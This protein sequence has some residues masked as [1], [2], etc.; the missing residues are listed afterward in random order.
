MKTMFLLT[1]LIS[2]FVFSPCLR[3]NP[4]NNI[5]VYKFDSEDDDTWD[6]KVKN[7]TK[8]VLKIQGNPT[9]GYSW[10]IK[11]KQMIDKHLLRVGNLG[12]NN[13]GHF[14]EPQVP[15]GFVGAPG[16]FTFDFDVLNTGKVSFDLI[17]KQPWEPE[18]SRTV[19]VNMEIVD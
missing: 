1:L 5:T 10:F 15:F 12:T 17:Y 7:G 11:N 9:T 19:T 4:K 8:I 13:E 14:E 3:V 6:L 18:E 2:W 16:Y